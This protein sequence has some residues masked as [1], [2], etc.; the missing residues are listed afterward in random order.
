MIEPK[1]KR[2]RRFLKRISTEPSFSWAEN[3]LINE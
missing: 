1:E 3:R 2:T